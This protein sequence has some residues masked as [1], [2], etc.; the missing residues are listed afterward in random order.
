MKKLFTYLF[1]WMSLH[2]QAQQDLVLT[3]YG[4]NMFVFNPA[5][6]GTE[7]YM[8]IAGINRLQHISMENAPLTNILSCNSSISNVNSSI[9]GYL[10]Q[11]RIGIYDHYGINLSYAYKM[12]LKASTFALGAGF[13]SENY[14][15]NYTR[16]EILD[17][18][19]PLILQGTR[20][21]WGFN[22]SFGMAWFNE[23][24]KIGFSATN[25]IP[26]KLDFGAGNVFSY[27]RHYYLM[28][29]KEKIF[30][31]G[32]GLSFYTIMSYT[33]NQPFQVEAH[34]IYN[35]Y[36]FNGGV[37]YRNQDALLLFFGM[38]LVNELYLNYSYDI[39]LNPLKSGSFGTSEIMLSYH[40]YY[41]PIYKK[42]KP[43]YK[44]I[45]QDPEK[46][47]L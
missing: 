30:S 23:T 17:P 34:V 11:D 5:F 35:F 26:S 9:G 24:S 22:G 44:W 14:R 12:E 32:T 25:L 40:F 28:A 42:A 6:T 4:E 39:T 47:K 7:M 36:R 45:K 41:D 21:D 31:E 20:G 10:F 33:A 16:A 15:L 43:R 18:S 3:N 38:N 29:M 2:V 1:C 27:S 13:T 37:G 8:Q 19:D 46:A